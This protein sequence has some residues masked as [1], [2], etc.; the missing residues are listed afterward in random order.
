M[1]DDLKESFIPTRRT[2]AENFE[3]R[4]INADP[5]Y[6]R[7]ELAASVMPKGCTP[8][9]SRAPEERRLGS[10]SYNGAPAGVSSYGG[11]GGAANYH[12]QRPYMP[13]VETPDRVQYPRSRQ[14]ANEDWRLFH[15]VD[16]IFG[17]AIDM[18]AEMLV[19][20]FDIVVGDE[21]STEIKNTLEY[22]CQVTNLQDRLRYIVREFLVLGEAVPH[23]FFDDSLGIWTYVGM[24]N[25]DYIEVIDA[26]IVN[27]DP[28]LNY[29]PDE[30]MRQLLSDGSPEAREFKTRLPAEFVSKIMARQKIRLSPLNTTFI[31][32]K[33]HPY[34][35][36]GTSLAS[37]LFRIFMV[38]DAVYAS[39]IANY[40][41]HANPV[42]VVKLGDAATGWIPAPG[43][44]GK[45]LE[46][47]TRAETDPAS[48]LV[49]NYG[50]SYEAWGTTGQEVNIAKTHDVIE[51]VKLL[52]LGLS[53]AFMSGEG[54]F[55]CCPAGTRVLSEDGT[56]R[57]IEE[58]KKG[59][60]VSDRFGQHQEVVDALRYE[61]PEEMTKI[62]LYGDRVLN[63][64]DNH[65]LPVFTRP[66]KCLCG[67]GE[68]LG[69]AKKVSQGHMKWRSFSPHHHKNTLRAGRD[70][71][72]VDYKNEDVVI[73]SFPS[74]HEPSQRLR[75]DE[76]RVG[77]WLMVPRKF[78]LS[79]VAPNEE[80]L[81]KARLLGYYVAE[82]CTSLT[83]SNSG[84]SVSN[85]AFGRVDSGKEAFY[86][87]D[88]VGVLEDLGCFPAVNT[89]H[90]SDTHSPCFTVYVPTAA[91]ELS[92]WLVGSAG[93]YS[94]GKSLSA[95]VMGWDLEL[96][97][98]LLKGMYRGDGYV[99]RKKV[100]GKNRLDV[101]Y[102][103]ASRQLS[104]QVERILAQLGFSS[105]LVEIPERVDAHGYVHKRYW[106]V[107]CSGKQA[108][109]LAE[110]VWGDVPDVWA[111]LDFTE[112]GNTRQGSNFSVFKDDDYLYIPVKSVEKVKVDKEKDPYVYSL[113]VANTNSYT[114]ENL[115][116]FN[117][118]KSGLQVFLRRLL[119]L[120]T[121][122]ENVWLYPKFFR[123]ISEVN[124]WTTAKPS[125][126]NHRYRIKRTAQEIQEENMVLMPTIKWRNKLDPS[127]DNDMLTALAMLEKLGL[128]I[129]SSTK[130]GAIGVDAS[131]ELEKSMK[132]FATNKKKIT[133][134]LGAE[135]A[136]EFLQDG[137]QPEGGAKPPGGPGA[138]AKPP[139]AAA[140]PGGAPGGGMDDA[141]RPPGSA[142]ENNDSIEKPEGGGLPGGVG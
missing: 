119:S 44:E 73:A 55:A 110:M 53:K 116:S 98:E 56:Y 67:C 128:K 31:A 97:R 115:A 23:N 92:E 69:D 123:P 28:I 39:T 18:Y 142:P 80:N 125:E 12:Y 19:S 91:T 118:S 11:G 141:S 137:Q 38:E 72:Y 120:R 48:W 59:D 63:L 114:L 15:R 81:E 46:M 33:M 36:R 7:R 130:G 82:G 113:T 4:I 29:V 13:Q 43:S 37:R 14:E 100:A 138:G 26:P 131:E 64:T 5:S 89:S 25:P 86:V 75:A 96:K 27:M 95:E 124:E 17:T 71:V 50:I 61:A 136:A 121:Y 54:T 65:E 84:N 117:S 24:H 101:T 74:E 60:L 47:L 104:L 122:L 3:P 107:A 127:V 112:F 42:K 132:E 41:R 103:T 87:A 99:F 21:K 34:D 9:V 10:G 133:N 70:R 16:P 102:T 57:P 2:A 58:I 66:R 129:S 106:M 20:E 22:M 76:V 79:D 90:N 78:D 30:H 139:G 52:G 35:I 105:R 49:W 108:Y 6:H 32:R 51:R 85:F 1:T 140:K 111:T 40:R 77:D 93:K 83:A 8:M 126:V 134:T 68:D 88:V 62:T 109:P 94:H 45:L 135:L